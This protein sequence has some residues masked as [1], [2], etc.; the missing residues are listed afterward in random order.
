MQSRADDEIEI[1]VV[2]QFSWACSELW[3]SAKSVQSAILCKRL[4]LCAMSL[5]LQWWLGKVIKGEGKGMRVYIQ[6]RWT[7]DISGNTVSF[8]RHWTTEPQTTSFLCPR[9]LHLTI[10]RGNLW[11]HNLLN[12]HGSRLS[13]VLQRGYKWTAAAKFWITPFVSWESYTSNATHTWPKRTLY[14]CFSLYESCA[15]PS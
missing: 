6:M 3:R 15:K 9:L 1:K 2:S 7:N 4:S 12:A 10:D 14:A 8:Q 13:A 5:L 11:P